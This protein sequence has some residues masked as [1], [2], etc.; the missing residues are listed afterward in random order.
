MALRKFLILR[1]LRSSYLEG[2]T[3]L[4]PAVVDFLTPSCAGATK[5]QLGEPRCRTTLPPSW[6]TN[7][8]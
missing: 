7:A 1:K 3:A 8:M 2:R 5:D 4:I 6:S